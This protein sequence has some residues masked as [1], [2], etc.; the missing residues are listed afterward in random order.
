MW[1]FGPLVNEIWCGVHF[2]FIKFQNFHNFHGESKNF[3]GQGNT[4]I[5]EYT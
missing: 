1:P 2:N 5:L 3:P 4:T